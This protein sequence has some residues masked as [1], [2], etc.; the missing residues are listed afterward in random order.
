MS[1]NQV[2]GPMRKDNYHETLE[3]P[4]VPARIQLLIQAYFAG[5][6]YCAVGDAWIRGSRK[7]F[8]PVN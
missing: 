4:L 2:L 7:T 6:T 5:R 3:R 8:L 1:L